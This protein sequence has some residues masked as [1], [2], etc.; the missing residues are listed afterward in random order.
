MSN[1]SPFCTCTDRKC[2]CHPANHDRGCSPCVAKNLQQG[3]IPS[4]FFKKVNPDEKPDAYF[5]EDFAKF[6]LK[7]RKTE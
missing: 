3:E 7:N 4:C 1:I 2:P 5:F 6:Y